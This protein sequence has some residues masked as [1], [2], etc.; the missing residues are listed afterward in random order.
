MNLINLLDYGNSVYDLNKKINFEF[1]YFS[2]FHCNYQRKRFT[3]ITN[4]KRFL[5]FNGF[6]AR[7]KD[8]K[9]QIFK[10]LECAVHGILL[11]G[12]SPLHA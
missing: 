7:K 10:I 2:F 6:I 3:Q 8:F 11:G 9:K 12:E 1:S 4:V 5:K